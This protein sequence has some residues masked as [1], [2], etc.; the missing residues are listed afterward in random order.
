M[1]SKTLE[2]HTDTPNLQTLTAHLLKCVWLGNASWMLHCVFVTQKKKHSA[3]VSMASSNDFPVYAS[4]LTL[5]RSQS[6]SNEG[7]LFLLIGW[8][9]L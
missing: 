5:N 6:A 9:F 4:P 2:L 3:D 8:K 1:Q 7:F